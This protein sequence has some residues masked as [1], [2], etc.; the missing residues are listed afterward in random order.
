MS[1]EI[2]LL[3]WLILFILIGIIGT[4]SLM[5]LSSQISREEEREEILHKIKKG[6]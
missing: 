3:I 1:L 2:F 4:I 6:E 5:V